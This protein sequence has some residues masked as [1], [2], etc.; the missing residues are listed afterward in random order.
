MNVDIYT[1]SA[2]THSIFTHPLTRQ[3]RDGRGIILEFYATR[4]IEIGDE[5]FFDYGAGW[6]R[7]WH[8]HVRKWSPPGRESAFA[9]YAPITEMNEK[10][11]PLRSR[12]ELRTNPY[13]NNVITGC[14][15]KE[16]NEESDYEFWNEDDDWRKLSDEKIL[17][18]FSDNGEDFT[19]YEIQQFPRYW[20]CDVINGNDEDGY[21]VQFFQLP[22]EEETVWTKKGVPMFLTNFP[23]ES[24]RFF[25]RLGA[26]D[27]YLPGAF[28]HHI[29][30][31][32]SIFPEQWKN[33][34][35][36]TTSP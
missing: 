15:Y 16:D 4:D 21:L 22:Q 3:Q 13:P 25:N 19:W 30:L 35:K 33:L 12:T 26:S 11:A 14:F 24:I 17:D 32:D 29:E 23:R 10:K 8:D 28:R 7:A 6:E 36:A 34:K 2:I 20:P 9:S 1:D 31:S 18:Y 5:I 27:Q